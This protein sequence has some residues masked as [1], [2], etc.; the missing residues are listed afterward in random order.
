MD[1]ELLT[2][3]QAMEARMNLDRKSMEGPFNERLETFETRLLTEFHKSA[4]S[5]E[6]RFNERLETFETRILTEFHKSVSSLEARFN[7]R[8][9]TVETRLLTEFHKW[10]SPMEARMRSHSAVL[11]AMDLEIEGLGERVD[12][13][14]EP[15]TTHQ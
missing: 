8:L 9:E 10:A 12:R 14:E 15:G 2:Y 3:L 4:S 7:E 13:L 1:P 5:L 11:R 6:A